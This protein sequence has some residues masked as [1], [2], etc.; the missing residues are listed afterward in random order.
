M[1]GMNKRLFIHQ[2]QAERKIRHRLHC[3][4]PNLFPCEKKACQIETAHTQCVNL[5]IFPEYF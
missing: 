1:N 5:L 4:G 3:N 2:F